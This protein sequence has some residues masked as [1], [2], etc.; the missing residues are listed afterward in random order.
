MMTRYSRRWRHLA[1]GLLLGLVSV[2]ASAGRPAKWNPGKLSDKA[3]LSASLKG[4]ARMNVLVRF[5][6]SPGA[7]EQMLVQGLGG[8]VRKPLSASSRWMSVSMPAH[9]VARLAEHSLV[10]FVAADEPVAA[11]AGMDVA[12]QAVDE[13]PVSAPESAFKG[14]GVT[15]AMVD[16][17]VALHPDIQTLTAAVDIVNPAL[18]I[19]GGGASLAGGD[20]NDPANSIDPNGHGT[21]VAPRT[22]SRACS[23]SWTTGRSTGSASSTSPSA[24]RSSSPLRSTRWC[25]RSMR[26]GTPVSW[27][28]ARPETVAVTDM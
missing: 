27:S 17:G 1:W 9:A 6:R 13:A 7:A 3:R 15:I 11:S 5:R 10:D 22:S 12:R 8:G 24:T 2:S 4:T 20:P 23:G 18:P 26:S 21:H 16:S 14:A 25:R 28:S 19:P